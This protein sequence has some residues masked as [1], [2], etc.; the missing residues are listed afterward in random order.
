MLKFSEP[1]SSNATSAKLVEQVVLAKLVNVQAMEFKSKN[2]KHEFELSIDYPEVLDELNR[3]KMYAKNLCPFPDSRLWLLDPEGFISKK[4]ITDCFEQLAEFLGSYPE[5]D[6]N[7]FSSISTIKFLSN[8]QIERANETLKS[9][10][11]FLVVSSERSMENRI[12]ISLKYKGNN[13]EPA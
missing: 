5:Y 7:A 4:F 3:L 11:P 6:N 10:G 12:F 9:T 8:P 2:T 1:H 13:T